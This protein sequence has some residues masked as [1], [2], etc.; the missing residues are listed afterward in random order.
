MLYVSLQQ[1]AP[2]EVKQPVPQQYQPQQSNQYHQAQNVA[3]NQYHQQPVPAQYQCQP[4]QQQQVPPQQ[5]QQM[6]QPQQQSQP[7]SHQIPQHHQ[8]SMTAVPYGQG[9][10]PQGSHQVASS[11][12]APNMSAQSQS[13]EKKPATN[14]DLLSSLDW[15]DV[16]VEP[17][18]PM[19][20][21]AQPQ[22]QVKNR[23]SISLMQLSNCKTTASNN[24]K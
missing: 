12:S 6:Q 11:S 23:F 13:A 22:Q 14:F 1:W 4:Q 15:N 17:L 10:M 18:A 9:Q 21:A 16:S 20:T 24:A 19:Q 8:T 5:Q 3:P 2:Q 7:Q